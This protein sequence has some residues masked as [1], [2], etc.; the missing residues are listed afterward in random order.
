M[1]TAWSEFVAAK[2]PTGDP[3]RRGGEAQITMQT[4]VS[5]PRGPFFLPTLIL[6]QLSAWDPHCVVTEGMVHNA[7]LCPPGEE[8]AAREPCRYLWSQPP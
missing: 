5:V 3:G 6:P 8:D 2:W 4:A 1:D 7:S